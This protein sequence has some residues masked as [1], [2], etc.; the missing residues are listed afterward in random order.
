MTP[1]DAFSTYNADLLDG[2][3]DCVDR[4]VLNAYFPVGHSPAGFRSWWRKLYGSDDTLDNAHL[5]RLAGRLARRLYAFAKEQQIPVIHCEPGIRKHEIAEVQQPTDPTFRGVF[6]ILVARAK[7]PLWDIKRTETTIQ[8][9]QRKE[10]FVNHYYFHIQDPEWG[11]LCIKFC[12]HPPFPVTIMLNGHEWV[13]RAAHDQGLTFTKEGNCFTN[14]NSWA[15][16]DQ[17]AETLSTQSAVGRL[18]EVIKRW[19]LSSCLIFALD[20]AEQEQS[21]FQYAFSC[22]QLEYSRNLVFQRGRDV[23]RLFQALI[24]RTRT[25]LDIKRLTTIFGAK[26]RPTHRPSSKCRRHA[27]PAPRLECSVETPTHDLTIFKCHF[28]LLA[29]K[30]YAKG[31]RVLR[32]E[33]IA[34]NAKALKQGKILSKLPDLVMALQRMAIRFLDVLRAAHP[35]AL[36]PEALAEL[37]RPSQVG[38]ARLAGIDLRAPRMR[39]VLHALCALGASPTGFRIQDLAEKVCEQTGWDATRYARRQAAY[40]FNKVRG[41]GLITRIGKTRRYEL[42]LTPAATVFAA[43]LLH[44]QIMTPVLSLV[45]HRSSKAVREPQH[46]IDRQYVQLRQALVSTMQAVGIAA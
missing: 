8:N 1:T 25:T 28:G 24:D 7:A 5:M 3:Y 41:K 19:L 10:G 34:H 12:G 32:I 18:V 40:D 45:A 14:A 33:A 37:G 23:D 20:Q 21:G 31:E 46:E 39:A 30:I 27:H 9:I 42:A 35:A 29:L 15:D 13:E 26:R 38:A 22:Y 6:L 44:E 11:H 4:L 17:H 43:L 16:L 36:D 2:R